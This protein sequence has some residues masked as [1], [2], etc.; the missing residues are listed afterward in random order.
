MAEPIISVSGLRGII[1]ESLDPLL[2]IGYGT[3]FAAELGPG[4]M[5]LARDG[6]ATGAMLTAALTA[7]LAAAGR[8]VIDLGVASTPTVGIAVRNRQAAGGIQVSASHNPPEYNGIKLFGPEGRVIPEAMGQRVLERYRDHVPQWVEHAAV[9]QI[10]TWPHAHEPHLAAILAIVD[11]DRIRARRFRVVLDANHASGSRLGRPLLEALGCQIVVLGETPDGRFAHPPEPVAENLASV[12]PRVVDE[13]AAV[14]FC[15]DPDADRLALIDESGQCLGEEATLALCVQ[16]VLTHHPS[17]GVTNCSTSRMTQDIANR[18]GVPFAHSRVGE[19]HV[20]D[21][22]QSQ[23]AFIGGEGNG[24]V[25][26]LRVGPVRDSFVGMAL[27]LEMLAE[28]DVPLSQLA[29]TLPQWVMVKHK[30]PLDRSQLDAAFARLEAAFPHA[31]FDRRDGLRVDTPEGWVLVRPSNTE[32]IVRIMGEAASQ[33]QADALC[34]QAAR[35]M[36]N[37]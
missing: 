6:R 2:A 36:G 16:H 31:S 4:P 10:T 14:G 27:I 21:A 17:P 8:D 1:G 23:G 25:I 5:L 34:D 11:V 15:Q 28:G 20:V 24:G 18:H 29:A 37:A 3:A 7:G 33:A 30:C 19:A 35:A 12:C 22:M 32:P 9:G 13:R 26:D